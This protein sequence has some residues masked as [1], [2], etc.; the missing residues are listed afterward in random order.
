MIVLSVAT[1]AYM[2]ANITI[3]AGARRETVNVIPL[4]VSIERSEGFFVITPS[5]PVIA[6]KDAAA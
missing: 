6:Q 4:P 2:L 3:A 5:I 1:A